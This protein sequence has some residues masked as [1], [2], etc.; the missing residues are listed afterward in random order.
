RASP[1]LCVRYSPRPRHDPDPAHPDTLIPVGEP[2]G[3]ER[4]VAR[5]PEELGPFV[6][7]IAVEITEPTSEETVAAHAHVP[8][9]LHETAP[10]SDPATEM[11]FPQSDDLQGS[12]PGAWYWFGP[13]GLERVRG[14]EEA[15]R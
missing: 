3:T 10:P 13:A 9:G 7:D 12:E 14:L 2:V 6:P 15:S 11:A 1:P 5:V 4:V 8:V